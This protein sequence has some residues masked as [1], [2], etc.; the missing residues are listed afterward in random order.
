MTDNISSKFLEIENMY[1]A[2]NHLDALSSLDRVLK[3]EP[4]NLMGLRNKGI[5]FLHLGKY[6]QCILK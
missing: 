2:K 3:M 5:I 4:E 1:N 6:E